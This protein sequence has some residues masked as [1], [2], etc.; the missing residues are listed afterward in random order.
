VGTAYTHCTTLSVVPACV[1]LKAYAGDGIKVR[2][3]FSAHGTPVPVPGAWLAQIRTHDRAAE[4]VTEFYID[5]SQENEGVIAIVLTG[6]QTGSMPPDV[7][8][9]WDLQHTPDYEEPR[10]YYRGELCITRDVS[11]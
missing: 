11:R 8:M 1:N 4:T 3:R 9:V 6:Q 5:E 10:T 7:S 2:F